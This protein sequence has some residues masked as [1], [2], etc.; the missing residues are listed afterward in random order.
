MN[1]LMI[2]QLS[3]GLGGAPDLKSR[4]NCE[5]FYKNCIE[6]VH[7]QPET[8]SKGLSKDD[9]ALWLDTSPKVRKKLC[10]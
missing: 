7:S 9:V 10:R 3:C 2:V 6:W 1:W 8:Q 5:Q 4:P